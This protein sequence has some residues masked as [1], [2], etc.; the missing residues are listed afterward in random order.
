[1][2]HLINRHTAEERRLSADRA[3]RANSPSGKS[4][5]LSGAKACLRC[6]NIGTSLALRNI[7]GLNTP[8]PIPKKLIITSS[9]LDAQET[10]PSFRG[11]PGSLKQLLPPILL[12]GQ[13]L[14]L[15]SQ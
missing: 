10:L 2:N 12:R 9:E 7:S 11:K 4:M 5:V 3:F 15:A 1:M 8:K 6:Q 13:T 14:R